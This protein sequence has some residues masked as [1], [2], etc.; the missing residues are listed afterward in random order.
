MAD[1]RQKYGDNFIRSIGKY[2]TGRVLLAELRQKY[3]EIQYWKSFI[4]ITSSK[5]WGNTV[6]DEFYWH[7]F[8]RSIGK[9][10][11]GRVLLAELR[12]KYGEIQYWKSFI[13]ITSSEVWGNTVLDEFYWQIFA[14]S[15]GEIQ[16]WKSYIGITSSEV[17]G[18]TVME[19]LYWHNFVRSMGKYSTGRVLLA[20]LRQKYGEIQY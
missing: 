14:R 12:Q 10:S 20:E 9:Y 19:E 3:G 17:W 4:G 1:L 11:T 18:N 16:Y 13:G 7:N 6:L 15:V 5:V 8:T 2:S